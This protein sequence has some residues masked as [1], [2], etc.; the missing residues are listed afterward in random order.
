MQKKLAKRLP[1]IENV[2]VMATR[3][4]REGQKTSPACTITA[5]EFASNVATK[6]VSSPPQEMFTD[7][8]LRASTILNVPVMGFDTER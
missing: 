3:I 7:L 2:A 4:E 1:G 5:K 8:R 6:D